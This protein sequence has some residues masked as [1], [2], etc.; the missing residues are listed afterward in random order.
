VALVYSTTVFPAWYARGLIGD[1]HGRTFFIV[2]LAAAIVSV[3]ARLHL[4]FTSRFYPAELDWV[5]QRSSRWILVADWVFA[6]TLAAGGI[7]IRDVQSPL[8]I[9]LPSIAIGVIVAAV[10]IEPVTTRDA[11]KKSGVG[12]VEKWKGGKVEK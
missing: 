11:F 10:L 7:L 1:W 2:L 4:W 12:E 6:V 9:V 5:H 8:T 3:T